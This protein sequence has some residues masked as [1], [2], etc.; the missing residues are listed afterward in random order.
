MPFST[1][2]SKTIFAPQFSATDKAALLAAMQ[3]A[4]NGSTIAQ[5]MFDNW[6]NAG[7]T[8]TLTL[9]LIF[10]F[11][12]CGSAR[13]SSVACEIESIVDS[14]DKQ[15]ISLIFHGEIISVHSI[16]LNSIIPPQ[17]A[18]DT[19]TGSSGY[20]QR[21]KFKVL[22]IKKGKYKGEYIDV[23]WAVHEAEVND[24]RYI[25]SNMYSNDLIVGVSKF[26][27]FERPKIYQK[28]LDEYDLKFTKNIEKDYWIPGGICD[29]Y[30][31]KKVKK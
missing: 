14:E 31:F 8:I 6:V 19:I 17:K 21:I 18:G 23:Y 30:Q 25:Y 4:Y 10:L 2:Q 28:D 7:K 24:L 27:E 13:A 5:A 1:V 16:Y 12:T 26:D 11:A 22:D 3:T 29:R 15:K 9:M 20:L